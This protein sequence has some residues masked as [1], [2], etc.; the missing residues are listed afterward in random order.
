MAR[1]T[2]DS[3]EKV[4]DA[5]DMV[6]LVGTR[7][8]LRKAGPARYEGLCPFHE[9]RS[10]SFGID[11]HK[12]V[13]HCFGCGAG[14][15]CFRYVQELE[16]LDFKGSLEFLAQRY[17]VELELEDED[18]EAA[19][20]RQARE[21]LLELLERT[22]T[23]YV[24]YLWESSEARRAREYLAERGL[25]EEVLRTFRV[26]YSPKAWD[27]VL[28]ASRKAGFSNR[29][30]YEAGLAKRAQGE[31]RI[32]DAF[33]GRVMFPLCDR[34]GRVLG[35]GARTLS[36]QDGPK[37]LNSN[38]NAVYHKG[39]HLFG[40]DLARSAAAKAGEV[41]LCEGYT[42]VIAL[43][44]AGLT[45]TVGQMG[46]AL[47]ADQV[48]E[49][50]R[51]APVVHMALDADE[52]GQNAM[53]KAAGVAR[54]RGVTL[55]VVE[56][57]A[58][59]DPAD[60]VADEQAGGAEGMRARVAAS[61]P[62]VTFRVRRELD[63]GDLA[64]AEGK[65]AVIAALRPVFAE[66]PPGALRE[67]LLKLVADRIDEKPS[68]VSGWLSG[69]GAAPAP[70]GGGFPSRGG[71]TPGR[72]GRGPA[73]PPPG[74]GPGGSAERTAAV[75]G[76]V[77]A[78]LDAAARSERAFLAAVVAFPH[79]GGAELERLDLDHAF[80]SDLHRRAARHL[81][82]HPGDPLAGI[83]PQDGELTALA[84]ELQVR[85]SDT[86]RSGALLEA[87]AR[88]V[89]LAMVDRQI[90]H[91]RA[92]GTGGVAELAQRRQALQQAHHQALER[93]MAETAAED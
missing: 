12:K 19:R 76:A 39:L 6:D 28:L 47:T 46:T 24:R 81:L 44:Q 72:P 7:V 92:Q 25:G 21:R 33:R 8:A 5:V 41:I 11:P 58:G 55:R 79:A 51:L 1:Y 70:P 87:E 91:A 67:E 86:A 26:G 18:P 16:G 48:A 42:D 53:L 66:L 56:L 30:V 89:E 49:L 27:K 15:D 71:G 34:R 32:F 54:G 62:F 83:D 22:A 57:P 4:R 45:N 84:A 20:R 64:N 35:F 9:E 37:Y 10:P 88:K 59:M 73:G 82:A 40:A 31:G 78:V 17:N 29:E 38:D 80:T 63:R 3:T 93:A 36:S 85:A 61:L 74:A 13:Y 69:A 43:H 23:F 77:R 2:K 75:G 60:V 65:D 68:L 52:A 14:G 90:A 50:G